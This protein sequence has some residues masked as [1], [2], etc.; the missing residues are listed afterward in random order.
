MLSTLAC[1]ITYIKRIQ[2]KI[3]L[4]IV[5]GYSEN[6]TIV[7]L[8]IGPGIWLFKW[9][10]NKELG[11]RLEKIKMVNDRIAGVKIVCDGESEVQAWSQS[12]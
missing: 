12:S 5:A 7:R 3:S 6:D 10:K 1:C 2:N 4:I 11:Y 9:K 8:F